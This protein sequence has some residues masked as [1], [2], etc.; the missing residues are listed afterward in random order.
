MV[1]D[2]WDAMEEA[3]RVRTL[4]IMRLAETARWS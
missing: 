1:A 2:F 4:G 3:E